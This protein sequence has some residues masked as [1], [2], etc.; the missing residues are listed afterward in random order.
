M[1]K[2]DVLKEIVFQLCD[3]GEKELNT[4]CNIAERI[5]GTISEAVSYLD[6]YEG[7]LDIDMVLSG[8]KYVL[9]EMILDDVYKM[10]ESKYEGDIYE[11]AERILSNVIETIDDMGVSYDERVIIDTYGH[12]E[13]EYQG[14]IKNIQD[15]IVEHLNDNCE[16]GDV[17]DAVED[18]IDMSLE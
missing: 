7:V 1:S 12:Y 16:Y 5:E 3:L 15:L 18:F 13:G 4:F 17:L 8:A 11:E 6:D 14:D 10:I 9:S 2:E